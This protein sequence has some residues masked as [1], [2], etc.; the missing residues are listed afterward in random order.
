MLRAFCAAAMSVLPSMPMAKVCTLYLTS[1]S[2]NSFTVRAAVKL[3]SRPP[4]IKIACI[5]GDTT[6]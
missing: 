2:F 5:K 1:S 3:E 4:A 6:F